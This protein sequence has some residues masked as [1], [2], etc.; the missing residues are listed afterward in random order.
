MIRRDGHDL[1]LS[2]YLQPRASRNEITGEHDGALRIR[3]T[4]APVDGKANEALLRFLASEFAVPLKQVQLESGDSSRRKRIRIQRPGA[5]PP[6]VAA[7]L[8]TPD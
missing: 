8:D 1:V 3:I 5:I 4:A 6:I 2:C 7:L